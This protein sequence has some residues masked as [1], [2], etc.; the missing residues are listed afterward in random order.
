MARFLW[1]FDLVA[2]K[3]RLKQWIVLD[4]SSFMGCLNR[5]RVIYLPPKH[6]D[7]GCIS[8]FYQCLQKQVT[9]SHLLSWDLSPCD[10][11][12]IISSLL[13]H[14]KWVKQGVRNCCLLAGDV[15]GG[16]AMSVTNSKRSTGRRKPR[17]VSW[18]LNPQTL[19]K[20]HAMSSLCRY[21]KRVHDCIPTNTT[22]KKLWRTTI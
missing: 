11:F 12:E 3:C 5:N 17:N 18:L 15:W 7:L 14:L 8:P 19:S 2:Q 22:F 6:G 16:T 9:E 21:V 1:S 20:K 10:L 4:N 13:E